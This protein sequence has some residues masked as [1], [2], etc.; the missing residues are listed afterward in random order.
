MLLQFCK[1]QLNDERKQLNT[2]TIKCILEAT[3]FTADLSSRETSIT[4]PD[5]IINWLSK[6]SEPVTKGCKSS[7][8]SE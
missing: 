6:I 3:P 5:P 2:P 7:T 1:L 4:C 8:F